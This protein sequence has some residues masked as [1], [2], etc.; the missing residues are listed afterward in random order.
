[1]VVLDIDSADFFVIFNIHGK[2]VIKDMKAW[3]RTWTFIQVP[4]TVSKET[5]TKNLKMNLLK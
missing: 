1:M 5:R 3:S 2:D 4:I